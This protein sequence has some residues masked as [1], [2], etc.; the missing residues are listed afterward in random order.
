MKKVSVIVPTFNRSRLLLET[1]ESVFSQTYKDYEII[2]VDDGSTDNTKQVLEKVKNENSDINFKILSQENKGVYSALNNGIKNSFGEYIAMLDSDDMWLEDYLKIMVEKIENESSK[3]G[4]VYCG[5][6]LTYEDESRE[7]FE[8]LSQYPSGNLLK[9]MIFRSRHISYVC[10]IFRR[11]A[12]EK[13]NYFDDFYRTIG[14]REIHYRFSKKYNYKF[15]PKH[16]VLDRRHSSNNPLIPLGKDMESIDYKMQI[17]KYEMH[18]LKKLLMDKDLPESFFIF[19][20]RIVSR[21]FFVWGKN[22]ISRGDKKNA[23]KYL[24]KSLR[25]NPFNIKS[26]FFLLITVSKSISNYYRTPDYLNN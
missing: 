17:N 3:T 5:R 18:W 15:I 10:S 12:L 7:V 8:D 11:E 23:K 1:L 9:Y 20:N 19:K 21:F 6:I 24:Y 13:I 26:F 22:F 2:V 16:L 25:Y 4:L 14:D